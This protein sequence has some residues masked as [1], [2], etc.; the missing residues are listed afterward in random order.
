M[1]METKIKERM[2]AAIRA[3][4]KGYVKNPVV[5]ETIRCVLF[6]WLREEGFTPVPAFRN[7]RYP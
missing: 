5:K 7:P 2:V 1:M 6:Q 4:P 3:I